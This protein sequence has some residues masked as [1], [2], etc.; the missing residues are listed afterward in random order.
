MDKIY[1]SKKPNDIMP[2]IYGAPYE[3]RAYEL[4]EMVSVKMTDL[5]SELAPG[6]Y[7]YGDDL[8]KVADRTRKALEGI[9]MSFI[10]P[11]HTVNINCA[12]HGFCLMGGDAYLEMLKTI[13]VVV[14]ERTGN[15]NVRL[16]V[17]MYRT[18]NEGKEVVD[19]YNLRELFDN[20]VEY[21]C[22]FDKGVPI[23]TQI[24]T[25]WGIEKAYDADW[26]IYAYYDDPREIYLHRFYRKALKAFTMNFSRYETRSCYHLG[27]GGMTPGPAHNIVPISIYESDFVQSKWA[28][29]CFMRTSPGGLTGIQAD[30]DLYAI[31]EHEM[32]DGLKNY[33]FTFHLFR[34]LEGYTSIWDGSRWPFYLHAGGLVYGV[35]EY[36]N[37]D[38]FDL[39][40]HALAMSQSRG[41]QYRGGPLGLSDLADF[42]PSMKSVVSN[43]CWIGL[44]MSLVPIHIP[45]FVVGHEQAELWRNDPNNRLFMQFAK[46]VKTLEEGVAKAKEITGN[47]KIVCFDGSYTHINCTRSLAEELFRKAPEVQRE[48]LEIH[49]PK[50]LK[51]RGLDPAKA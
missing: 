28:F 38:P 17:V 26:F 13:K 34:K 42:P 49:Y 44:Q 36:S 30:K 1:E 10:K 39:D 14:E 6:F 24:G 15:N 8:S 50:Y 25:L 23:E 46:E 5:F 37:R 9:D 22:A 48:V 32:I 16:R 47:D 33:A 19:Y 41:E 20:K 21:T 35:M 4:P 12:E 45:T 27:F 11:E 29:A 40:Q 18:P 43:H 7:D 2:S 3:K 31:D 51:Q